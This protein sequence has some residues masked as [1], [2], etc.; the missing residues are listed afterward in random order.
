MQIQT[1][2]AR[3]LVVADSSE[4]RRST[5]G[6]RILEK[7]AFVLDSLRSQTAC[8]SRKYAHGFG[9]C[10]SWFNDVESSGRKK[11]FEKFLKSLRL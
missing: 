7:N 1:F 4:I 11:V 3:T 5:G 8:C 9:I 2:F 6:S 10:D